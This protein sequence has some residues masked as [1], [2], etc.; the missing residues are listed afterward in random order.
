MKPEIWQC[1]LK[2]EFSEGK[3]DCKTIS[4]YS[5]TNSNLGN[6]W[7]KPKL[8]IR[9]RERGHQSKFL[10]RRDFVREISTILNPDGYVIRNSIE[11]FNLGVRGGITTEATLWN[12][13]SG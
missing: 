8:P 10:V 3:R 6:L 9:K 5:G 13:V 4:R 2:S 1:Y 7:Y 12:I 11:L